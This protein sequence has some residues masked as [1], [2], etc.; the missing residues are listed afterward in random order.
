[1]GQRRDGY[2]LES[3]EE[4]PPPIF[5]NSGTVHV[6]AGFIRVPWRVEESEGKMVMDGAW[7]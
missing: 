1:M 6:T 4:R 3:V 7:S 2:G 5:P